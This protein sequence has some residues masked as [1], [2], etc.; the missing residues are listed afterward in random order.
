MT[1][2][3]GWSL[4]IVPAGHVSKVNA[5]IVKGC[6]FRV[7]GEAVMKY[8]LSLYFLDVAFCFF[9]NLVGFFFVALFLEADFSLGETLALRAPESTRFLVAFFLYSPRDLFVDGAP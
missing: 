6:F 5:G 1:R 7:R 3:I 9:D 4:E 2:Q 8:K